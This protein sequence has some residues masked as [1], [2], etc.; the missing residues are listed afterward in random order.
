MSICTVDAPV[1]HGRSLISSVDHRVIGSEKPNRSTSRPETGT[2]RSQLR[3]HASTDSSSPLPAVRGGGAQA[4]PGRPGS[5]QQRSVGS[6]W[7]R[8]PCSAQRRRALGYLFSLADRSLSLYSSLEQHTTP[9]PA[10]RAATHMPRSS[11][12][13]RGIRQI[14]GCGDED[15]SHF[16]ARSAQRM[17]SSSFWEILH[18]SQ[19]RG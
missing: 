12:E 2:R 5:V 15:D 17:H 7:R 6:S 11:S 14:R 1:G 4:A 18:S 9:N 16:F 19:F 8:R 3:R 13:R 10:R